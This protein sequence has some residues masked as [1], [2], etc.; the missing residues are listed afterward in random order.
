MYILY[1]SKRNIYVSGIFLCY[2][3]TVVTVKNIKTLRLNSFVKIATI[4][5]FRNSVKHNLLKSSRGVTERAVW[6]VPRMQ[7]SGITTMRIPY[8]FRV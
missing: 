5:T 4:W 1:F 6:Q 3:I 2:S 8:I 7:E